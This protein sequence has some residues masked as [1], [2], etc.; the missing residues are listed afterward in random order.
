MQA[1]IDRF[2]AIAGDQVAVIGINIGDAVVSR[3]ALCEGLVDICYGHDLR[4]GDR[5]IVFKMVL[6]SLSRADQTDANRSVV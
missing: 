2:N 3:D 6:T 5:C 4:A 1:N